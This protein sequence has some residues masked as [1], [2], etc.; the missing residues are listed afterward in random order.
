[1]SIRVIENEQEESRL[2]SRIDESKWRQLS[3]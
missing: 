3:N 1:V 2:A